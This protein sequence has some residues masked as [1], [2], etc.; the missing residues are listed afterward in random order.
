MGKQQV[1][2]RI[3]QAA[4]PTDYASELE[5]QFLAAMLGLFHI[6]EFKSGSKSRAEV[7]SIRCSS[8][9]TFSAALGR[10]GADIIQ[11]STHGS[12]DKLQVG[13]N[14]VTPSDLRNSIPEKVL[15]GSII[16]TTTCHLGSNDWQELFLDHLGADALIASDKALSWRD[17]AIFGSS[18]YNAYLGQIHKGHDQFERAWRSFRIA[19]AAYRSFVTN[20][21]ERRKID[22]YHRSSVNGKKLLGP[23]E[24]P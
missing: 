15:D 6:Q 16:L 14:N 5:V 11:I 7:E 21:A 3:V 2:I 22:F 13:L 17:V 20:N 10:P 4:G 1:T 9:S 12:P 24:K 19:Y 18:F 8:S 23:I